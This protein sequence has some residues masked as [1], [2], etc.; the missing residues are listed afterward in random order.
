MLCLKKFL[1]SLGIGI[2]VLR[3]GRVVEKLLWSDVGKALGMSAGLG[4]PS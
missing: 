4:C 2:E 3:L 1:G